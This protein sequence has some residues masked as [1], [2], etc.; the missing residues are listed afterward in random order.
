MK[1][2][3]FFSFITAILGALRNYSKYKVFNTFL[4]IRTPIIS[5]TIYFIFNHFLHNVIVSSLFSVITERWFFLLLK[6]IT[7]IVNNDY[8]KKK[9]KYKIKYDMIY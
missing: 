9:E 5:T 1:Y 6:T 8:Y 3:I 4:F 2:V 7:S